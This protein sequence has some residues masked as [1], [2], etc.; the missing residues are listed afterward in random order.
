MPRYEGKISG[1][2]YIID[3]AHHPAG[4]TWQLRVLGG[5]YSSRG[6]PWETEELAITEAEE[7]AEAVIRDGGHAAPPG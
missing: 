7:Q 2:R 6:A 3:T 1:F 5:N 4:W